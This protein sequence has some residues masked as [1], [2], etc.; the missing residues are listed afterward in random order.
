MYLPRE[1]H[2]KIMKFV[3]ICEKCDKCML[4]KNSELGIDFDEIIKDE[5]FI[6]WDGNDGNMHKI[7]NECYWKEINVKVN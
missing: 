5:P 3:Y 4:Q 7:C 6:Y 2:L 1:I